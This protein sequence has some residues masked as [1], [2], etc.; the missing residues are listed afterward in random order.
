MPL[1]ASLVRVVVLVYI[2]RSSPTSPS[3]YLKNGLLQACCSVLCVV[4]LNG[5]FFDNSFHFF[6]WFS[7][8][9]WNSGFGK[10]G[11]SL[12]RPLSSLSRDFIAF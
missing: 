8:V 9:C 11:Y 12:N 3:G 10:L 1:F 4:L 6:H 5:N 7:S 2:P